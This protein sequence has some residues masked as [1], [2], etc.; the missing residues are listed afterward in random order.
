MTMMKRIAPT[1]TAAIAQEQRNAPRRPIS[2]PSARLAAVIFPFLVAI[3]ELMD[4]V[5]I[6][7]PISP[8]LA[9]ILGLLR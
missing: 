7:L 6:I 1:E 4:L 8:V 9:A 2:S 5:S 3:A